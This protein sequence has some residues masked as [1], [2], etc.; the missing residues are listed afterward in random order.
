MM[1]GGVWRLMLGGLLRMMLGGLL[2][3]MLGRC[4]GRP[5]GE[6]IGFKG[7]AT[8]DRGAGHIATCN[9]SHGRLGDAR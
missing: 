5:R 8:L 1:L 9:H 6:V 3:M 7:A 4:T 2:R